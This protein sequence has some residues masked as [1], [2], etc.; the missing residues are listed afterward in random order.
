MKKL[1][2]IMLVVML[3]GC[4]VACAE[5][6][7]PQLDD[8]FGIEVPSMSNSL[9]REPDTDSVNEEGERIQTFGSVTEEDYQAFSNYLIRNGCAVS[10][11]SLDGSILN[12]ILK[13]DEIEFT[14]DY[15][16][17][18]Q[19]AVISYPSSVRIESFDPYRVGAVV[20]FGR[21]EQDGNENNGLE[22]IEWIVIYADGDESVLMSKYILDNQKFN[23]L[24]ST[25]GEQLWKW[26][27]FVLTKRIDPDAPITWE[28]SDLREWLN[29]SFY[30]VAFNEDEKDRI[31]LSRVSNPQNPLC[32]AYCGNDTEDYVYL[33]GVDEI[34]DYEY[35]NVDSLES[36]SIDNHY[37]EHCKQLA[38]WPTVYASANSEVFIW[39]NQDYS[40]HEDG[41]AE[42]KAF[43]GTGDWWLR[44]MDSFGRSSGYE[45]N[46]ACTVNTGA[47]SSE[48]IVFS[49]G[50]RPIIRITVR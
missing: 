37:W 2:A 40:N 27:P 4:S 5:G 49:H 20:I 26:Q 24:C 36:I 31:V 30:N 48:W 35:F 34:R 19:Q 9:G 14:L 29:D 44:T 46:Y 25:G 7:L 15:D 39:A 33:L 22:P 13:K 18:N 12:V 32:N 6:L 47:I 28:N 3:L 38:A 10:N 41:G 1:V 17:E 45:S 8:A 11:Y 23:I 21:Y 43:D 50:I 16:I 42:L